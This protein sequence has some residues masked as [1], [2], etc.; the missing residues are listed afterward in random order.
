MAVPRV[1]VSHSSIDGAFTVRLDADL[2]EA[3]AIVYRVS[4]DAGG[5]FQKRINDAL[6]TCEWV[7]LVLTR[8]ALA[9][10]WVEQ[11]INAAIRLKNQRRIE[12]ILPVQAGP[13]DLRDIPPLWGVYN[14]F[15]ATQ[16]YSAALQG[17]LR[18]IGLTVSPSATSSLSEERN[19]RPDS[20]PITPR[21]NLTNAPDIRRGDCNSYATPAGPDALAYQDFWVA[22]VSDLRQ[23][24]L[25]YTP[26]TID[27]A[28]Y[29]EFAAGHRDCL[30]VAAFSGR[31][32]RVSFDIHRKDNK[33]L[34]DAL[35]ARKAEIEQ[36][37]G[38]SLEWDRN[39]RFNVSH[40]M[41]VYPGA[42]TIHDGQR[43][44]Q[45][46]MAWMADR[47]LGLQR[48]LDVQLNTL[49]R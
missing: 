33:A 9:S 24:G 32:A 17:V 4:A 43:K 31:Q 15:D 11:E 47:L 10:A 19:V 1:F 18:A 13:V 25:R 29:C 40:I 39:N 8:N 28:S 5:D 3:G 38:G 49:D 16:D 22:L 35:H 34:F 21:V 42:V 14:V 41:A 7:V 27:C 37:L 26:S 48:C 36:C 12:D 46:V 44:L 30:Y 45:S 20:G 23:R 6:A 2:R